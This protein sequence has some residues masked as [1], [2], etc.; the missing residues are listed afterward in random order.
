MS[1]PSR[2]ETSARKQLLMVGL[3]FTAFA[4]GNAD[5][6]EYFKI[7]GPLVLPDTDS[8]TDIGTDILDNDSSSDTISTVQE[9][10]PETGCPPID[11][12]SGC[13][14]DKPTYN[15]TFEGLELNPG[16]AGS[17]FKLPKETAAWDTEVETLPPETTSAAP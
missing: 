7:H 10:D 11:W 16:V 6:N 12:G 14:T 17:S 8:Q 15:V 5:P 2:I 3:L 9:S 4:C 13:K 1:I